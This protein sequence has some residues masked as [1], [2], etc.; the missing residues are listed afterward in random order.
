H[1]Y[2]AN[3]V[4]VCEAA[5]F[6]A[7]RGGLR[8]LRAAPG[9]LGLL[10]DGLGYMTY[11]ARKR[12]PFLYSH[13]IVRAEGEKEVERAVIARV[14]SDWKP[15]QGTEQTIDVDTICIGYGFFPSVEL[16]RLCGCD[17]RYD[18]DL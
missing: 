18:E 15:V 17:H 13:M 2:G 6:P 7:L 8:L 3:V 12:V 1:Q 4:T 10:S 9:N 11:L 14:G 5:G 16:S